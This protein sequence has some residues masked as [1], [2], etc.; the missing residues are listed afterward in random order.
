[1]PFRRLMVFCSLQ[2]YAYGIYSVGRNQLSRLIYLYIGCRES[3]FASQ[4][5]T[6]DNLSGKEIFIS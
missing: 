1:M 2:K 5:E 6:V 3:K 4:F